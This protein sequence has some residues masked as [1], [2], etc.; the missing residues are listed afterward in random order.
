VARGVGETAPVLLTSGISA[1]MN[2]N[3]RSNPMMSLPLATY[4]FVRSPQPTQVA[5]G[6]ATAAVLM[7]LVLMLFTAARLLAGRA[8]GRLSRRQAR[9]VDERSRRDLDRIQS[10][11]EVR[12]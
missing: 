5:R 2:I 9:R 1:S 4:E 11:A 7:I 8:P 6:F 12:T 10:S 3:P